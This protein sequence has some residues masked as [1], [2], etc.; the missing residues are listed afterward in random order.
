MVFF[1]VSVGTSFIHHNIRHLSRI[2]P[3]GWRTD[4]SNYSPVDLWNVG[5]QIGGCL[6]EACLG[7]LAGEGLQLRQNLKPFAARAQQSLGETNFP[8][9]A[10]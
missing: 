4:S 3:A 7:Y 8:N 6:W 9:N 2:Y 5:C 1:P 10:Q